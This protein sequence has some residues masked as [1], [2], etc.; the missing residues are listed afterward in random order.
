MHAE[1]TESGSFVTVTGS[2]GQLALSVGGGAASGSP[3]VARTVSPWTDVETVSV[4]RAGGWV[5]AGG[6]R[7]SE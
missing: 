3:F 1:V 5:G 6:R 2:V 7:W 4:G